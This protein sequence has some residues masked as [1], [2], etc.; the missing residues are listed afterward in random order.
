M[1]VHTNYVKL[2]A[3]VLVAVFLILAG[4]IV[5]GGGKLWRERILV[6][7]YLDESAQ[8]LEKGTIVKM[9]GVDVGNIEN[10]SFVHLKYPEAFQAGHR[11]VLVEIGLQAE[12]FGDFPRDRFKDILTQEIHNGLRIRITPQGL[13][14]A[15]FLELDYTMPQRAP[16][17]PI[18]WTP[19]FPYIPSAPGTIARF[20][21]TFESV[22]V[23]LRNLEEV[24]VSAPLERLEKLLILAGDK[25]DALEAAQFSS[26]AVALLQELRQT[27]AKVSQF[28]GPQ[29]APPGQGDVVNLQS[30]FRDVSQTMADVRVVAQTVHTWIEDDQGGMGDLR[31][32]IVDL[33]RTMAM[34]PEMIEDFSVTMD[35]AHESF[36]LFQRL[37]SQIQFRLA[38]KL[39]QLDTLLHNLGR[40]SENLREITE[41]ARVY[42][43]RLFFGEPPIDFQGREPQP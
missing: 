38:T 17:L 23:T 13:T 41:D 1:S 39:E 8:G 9:R 35:T 37:L 10:I 21:E 4:L 25:L 24:N 42:P 31:Q 40:T 32:A 2:G 22:S 43:S 26:E 29:D 30:I 36:L 15:A 14:G 19:K 20:E 7:T 6:E 27:N 28:L 33:R 12:K 3:F 16:A 11:Y 5:L 18:N 34:A